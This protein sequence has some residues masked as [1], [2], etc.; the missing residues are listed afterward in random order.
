MKSRLKWVDENR[1]AE[2]NDLTRP[3]KAFNHEHVIKT[4]NQFASCN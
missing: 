3:L 2:E 1:S 4:L